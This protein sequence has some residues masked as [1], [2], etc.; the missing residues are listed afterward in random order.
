M[1][2]PPWDDLSPDQRAAAD[3][4]RQGP[5]GEIT[6]PFV[7]LLRDPELLRRVQAIGTHLRF[8]DLA[9]T[10]SVRELTVLA[11]ARFWEQA[12]EWSYHLPLAIAAGVPEAA[13]AALLA[14]DRPDG[15]SEE[16]DI[17]LRLVVELQRHHEIADDTYQRAAGT[18]GEVG[19]V[20]IT[21]TAGYYTTL[22]MIMNM[23]EAPPPTAVE[24]GDGADWLN[25][26]STSAS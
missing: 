18:F 19:V 22:A 6:G 16:L 26:G 25:Y 21:T 14:G 10:P 20:E 12:F 13:C 9:I 23:A 3:E 1:Q 17:T 11:V 7:A 8:T 4:I 24:F 2:M 15:L 5:R